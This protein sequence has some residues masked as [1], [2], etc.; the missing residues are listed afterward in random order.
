MSRLCMSRL[1]PARRRGALVAQRARAR[2][3]RRSS[4]RRPPGGRPGAGDDPR[5]PRRRKGVKADDTSGDPVI[6]A[7]GDIACD[8]DGRG[9][10]D[11]VRRH[12]A[13]PG[14]Q[15]RGPAAGPVDRVGA[16]ARRRPVLQRRPRPVLDD[17]RQELGH[18]LR[19][20]LP[21]AGQP[22]VLRRRRPGQRLLLLLRQ[23]R[24]HRRQGVVLLRHRRLAPDRAQ[25]RQLHGDRRLLT[26]VLRATRRRSST[27]GWSTTSPSTP[28]SASSPTGTTR[29]SPAA[30]RAAPRRSAGSS[31]RSTT[32]RPTSSSTATT[33]TTSG[34]PSR[35]PAVRPSRAAAS[36]SSSSAPAGAATRTSAG[37]RRPTPRC[38]STTRSACSR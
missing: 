12:D 33:T 20:D 26:G 30:A 2:G 24:R 11:H 5:A 37:P 13:V 29:S 34:S 38:A 19:Q 1:V 22:R 21:G 25:H 16:R 10:G 35:T 17:V 7:A 31:R 15:D 4:D 14:G 28:T 36:A 6:A 3:V 8:S 27:P 32:R 18:R 9:G 23:P